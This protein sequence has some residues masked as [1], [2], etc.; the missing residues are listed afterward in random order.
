MEL[1][2]FDLLAA[3]TK[4]GPQFQDHWSKFMFNMDMVKTLKKDKVNKEKIIELLSAGS[5][6][7][8]GGWTTGTASKVLYE[9]SGVAIVKPQIEPYR[10]TWLYTLALILKLD[11]PTVELP[12]N[13]AEAAFALAHHFDH[14]AD[15]PPQVFPQQA[16]DSYTNDDHPEKNCPVTYRSFCYVQLRER[17]ELT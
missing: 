9:L 12:T 1:D 10:D 3:L 17:N 4:Q 11:L 14:K 16:A 8:G 6:Y 5:A 2:N 15:N 7:L 13:C